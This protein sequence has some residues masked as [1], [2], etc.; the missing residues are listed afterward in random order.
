MK[1]LVRGFEYVRREMLENINN[2]IKSSEFR[3]PQ[4]GSSTSAGYDFFNISDD[5][6]IKP[7]ETV[8][9]WTN[10]KAY[11]LDDEF[12][13]IYPRSS[14][15]I[16]QGLIL[17]NSV[18]IIDSDY[19][20]NKNNDGNIGIAVKNTSSINQVIK[21]DEAYAQ[22]IFMSYLKSDNCNSQSIRVGGIGS[23]SK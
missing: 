6:I 18:G 20:S 8:I 2:G 4:R 9:L 5:V 19:Y 15:G 22:G 21:K 23:T 12:L 10:I 7:G 13:A 16:K 1:D 14:K 11:M 3:L 17:A